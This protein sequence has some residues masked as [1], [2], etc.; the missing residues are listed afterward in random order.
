[1]S[2]QKRARKRKAAE[3]A[4]DGVDEDDQGNNMGHD[5]DDDDD[6]DDGGD[7]ELEG[8][9]T[10]AHI[11]ATRQFHEYDPGFSLAFKQVNPLCKLLKSQREVFDQIYTV[12]C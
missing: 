8:A 12:H 7:V 9:W 6:D 1:M 5:D 10:N 11:L 3:A 2:G 4:L